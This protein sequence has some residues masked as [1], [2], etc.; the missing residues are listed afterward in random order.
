VPTGR[1]QYPRVARINELVREILAEE[2][3]LMA[4]EDERLDLVTV[5]GVEAESDLRRATVFFSARHEGA[6]EALLEHRVKLQAAIARQARFKRTP[7]LAFVEDHGV[8]SGWR[9][10]GIL[11]EIKEHEDEGGS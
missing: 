5:T 3:E 11:K 2:L 8:A 1:R 9:I 4:D 10:E 7:Q 6:G